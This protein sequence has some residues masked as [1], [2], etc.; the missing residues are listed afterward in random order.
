VFAAT[1]M[2]VGALVES[3]VRKKAP[4]A[5]IA[6]ISHAALDMTIF[7]HARDAQYQWPKGSFPLFEVV[8]YPHD[9]QS[10]LLVAALI[11][12]T[13]AVAVLLR[14]YWWGMLWALLPD[15]IEWVILKPLTGE[16]PIHDLFKKVST[17]WGF[18]VE[19]LLVVIVVL[20]LYLRGRKRATA[21]DTV[22]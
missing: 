20:V 2:A 5:L 7:W 6:L 3:R 22:S 10:W 8:P 1:H 21:G 19:M 12:S 17:P 15:I 11:V 14:R 9:L 13:V 4:T 16:H 18:A